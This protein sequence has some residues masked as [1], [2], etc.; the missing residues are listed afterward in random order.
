MADDKT[1]RGGPDRR[2]VAGEQPY[3][4]SYFARKHGITEEQAQDLIERI[5]NDREAL[6]TAARK[7]KGV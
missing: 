1:K 5:G 7:M 2:R 6:D 3:E 4:V